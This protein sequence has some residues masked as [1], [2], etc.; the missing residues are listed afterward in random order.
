MNFDE[1]AAFVD[2]YD[3]PMVSELSGVPEA[4]LE[5]LAELY[6]DP[7]VKVT[8]FWTMGFNQHTR[9]VWANQMV[10]NL[11]L[12]TGRSAS[13]RPVLAL[14]SPPPAGRR[15]RVGT[16]SH[17]LPADMLVTSPASRQ[18]RGAVEAAAGDDRR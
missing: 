6:A 1:F 10:Y 3:G 8:S 2:A 14:A 15:A 12:L 9:G 7:A 17:R 18:D 4:R 11:H 13:R 16:F 5:A